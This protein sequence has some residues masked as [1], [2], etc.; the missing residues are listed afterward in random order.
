MEHT[1]K[2]WQW[3]KNKGVSAHRSAIVK[4]VAEKAA[5]FFPGIYDANDWENDDDD[6]E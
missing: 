3:L 1:E 5:N 6:E 2:F 4:A